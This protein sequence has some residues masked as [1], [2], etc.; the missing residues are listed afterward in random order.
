VIREKSSDQRF[1]RRSG[2]LR[3]FLGPGRTITIIVRT[4][5]VGRE[6][7]AAR[8]TAMSS[9]GEQKT[10]EIPVMPVSSRFF[11]SPAKHAFLLSLV[12]FGVVPF[13]FNYEFCPEDM[14][15]SVLEKKYP[16][17]TSSEPNDAFITAYLDASKEFPPV[18]G[19]LTVQLLTEIAERAKTRYFNAGSRDEIIETFNTMTS[20]DFGSR[21]WETLRKYYPFTAPLVS[22]PTHRRYTS[23]IRDFSWV[24]RYE[25]T[26]LL[27]EKRDFEKIRRILKEKLGY[28]GRRFDLYFDRLRG[29]Y[30]ETTVV[31]DGGL[32]DG[33]LVKYTGLVH[34]DDLVYFMADMV[35]TAGR[36]SCCSFAWFLDLFE[37]YLDRR[38]LLPYQYEAQI[39]P[40]D[41]GALVCS[42][43]E[44]EIPAEREC[45]LVSSFEELREVYRREMRPV[46]VR[47]KNV[48]RL[49][50]SFFD[51]WKEKLAV[52][53][54]G[55]VNCDRYELVNPHVAV[56]TYT[57]KKSTYKIVGFLAR[58]ED[59][60]KLYVYRVDD[61]S[62]RSAILA[63]L[64]N[65]MLSGYNVY[66]TR[67]I[68]DLAGKARILE[69]IN[70]TV[71]NYFHDDTTQFSLGVWETLDDGNDIVWAQVFIRPWRMVQPLVQVFVFPARKGTSEYDRLVD[72]AVS[73]FL[74][75]KRHRSFYRLNEKSYRK[76]IELGL[77][78]DQ[79]YNTSPP[80]VGYGYGNVYV[81]FRPPEE[82]NVEYQPSLSERWLHSEP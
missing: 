30:V 17:L 54:T 47:F 22:L 65:A 15:A 3:A 53:L 46:L 27:V 82:T 56:G 12:G 21:A 2:L 19:P 81:L 63:G 57:D 69:R 20:E 45:T 41:E 49:P 13:R 14:F 48:A 36:R 1:I 26:V 34:L 38:A 62:T 8:I 59:K 44:E 4:I 51:G 18:I 9:T 64:V 67:N 76:L 61:F 79:A 37:Q 11:R 66:D 33:K 72:R 78:F 6:W 60:T 25:Y 71:S 73:K 52:V 80:L 43:K 28:N 10:F 55:C 40:L 31:F 16:E 32:P 50:V 58:R 42:E 68:E 24:P 29:K 70:T 39:F 35:R 74:A 5:M 75:E 23:W 77:E 7:A